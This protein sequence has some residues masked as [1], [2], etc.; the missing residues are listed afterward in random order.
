[1]TLKSPGVA[2]GHR[3][4][5]G[6]ATPVPT[7]VATSAAD[8]EECRGLPDVCSEAHHDLRTPLVSVVIPCYN[9]AHFLG[10]AIES[11]VNQTYRH[12]EVVV[13][14]DG[15]SD[16]TSGIAAHFPGVRYIKQ[17]NQGLASAR[18]VG[19][20]ASR[21]NYLV[22][23]DADDRLL[24]TALDAGLNCFA[25]HPECAFVSGAH[26]RVS[27]DGSPLGKPAM[28]H[29]GQ[30]HYYAMLHE[31]Y[32]EMHATVMYRRKVLQS[33][34]GF[35]TSLGAC[36]D[37][38]L[39]LRITR[40]YSVYC[41]DHVVAEYRMHDAQMSR[42]ALLMLKAAMTA[43]GSQWHHVKTDR[44]YRRAYKAGARFWKELYGKKLANQVL[45]L[46]T[47]GQIKQ[48]VQ[49]TMVFLRYA[50]V[51]TMLRSA[52][53]WFAE[54]TARQLKHLSSRR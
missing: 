41:H 5:P 46:G 1:M 30:D 24:P 45:S 7:A 43:L 14:D 18:N 6:E 34:N 15:S 13:V 28:P 4:P 11:V 25:A 51:M 3:A 44:R 17:E 37:Y 8:P 22:F 29:G 10:E 31:N 39:F 36:E 2:H 53:V 47:G 38:D 20:H 16:H 26:I 33:V 12:F 49:G 40:N 9:Q 52:P 42:D 48:A 19:I 27:H 32:I 21:G 54:I 35:D 50:G 23:L